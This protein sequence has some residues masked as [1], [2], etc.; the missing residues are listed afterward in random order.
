MSLLDARGDGPPVRVEI[1]PRADRAARAEVGRDEEAAWVGA[2]DHR[3]RAQRR[4][5]PDRDAP[6]AMVV[7]R[8][9]DERLAAD[10]E[11][12][13]AVVDAFGRLGQRE[14]DRAEPL[15]DVH[16]GMLRRSVLRLRALR[17]SLGR[18]R[19]ARRRLRRLRCEQAQALFEQRREGRALH[20]REA[21]EH[22]WMARVVV[23]QEERLRVGVEQEIAR[24]RVDAD[25]QGLPVL[26]Q[27]REQLAPALNAAV[28]YEV[29]SST[30]GSARAIARASSNV[31]P[32]FFAF[33]GRARVFAVVIASPPRRVGGPRARSP[34]RAIDI[35][36]VGL[37]VGE[38][39][40]RRALVERVA[41]LLEQPRDATLSGT[42]DA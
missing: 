32:L 36:D 31:R 4:L 10:L 40:R 17:R 42:I 24:L 28:P 15:E 11:A 14:A 12:R 27:A 2:D 1:E 3:L 34:A 20:A 35:D 9:H 21:H 13:R 19:G 6:V 29:P 30:P 25:D 39:A 33:A 26:A 18:G 23:R 5:A 37:L 8:E 16:P 38:R 7:V 41:E 22:P